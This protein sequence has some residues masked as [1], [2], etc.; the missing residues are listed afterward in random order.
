[1]SRRHRNQN[2]DRALID[3]VLMDEAPT[4]KQLLQWGADVNTRDREHLETPLM[5]ARSESVSQLLLENGADAGAVDDKGRTAFMKSLDP[6]H[7]R[8]GMNI[9]AQDCNGKTALMTAVE[10]CV[11]ESIPW[12]L[13]NGADIHIVNQWG[14]TT[15]T[16]AND[17]GREIRSQNCLIVLTNKPSLCHTYSR[18]LNTCFGINFFR[19]SHE[20]KGYAV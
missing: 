8:S 3:A 2:F 7:F 14:E 10:L 17:Y 1:M 18:C 20:A 4:V 12:L 16:L 13:A 19:N 11:D 15:L 9:N 5:L 6:T